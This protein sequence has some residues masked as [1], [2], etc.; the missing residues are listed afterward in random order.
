MDRSRLLEHTTIGAV[1]IIRQSS[2][3][4]LVLVWVRSEWERVPEPGPPDRHL[5]D[6]SDLSDPAQNAE[7]GELLRQDRGKI[8]DGLPGSYELYLVDIEKDDLSKLD[9]VPVFDWYLDTG[10]TFRVIDTPAH[11]RAGR[12]YLWTTGPKAAGHREKVDEIAPSLADYDATTT[13]ELLVLIAAD[14]AGPYV[15]IDGTHRSAALYR[16]HLT[17]TPWRAILALADDMAR[18]MWHID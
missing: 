5:I 15:I 9:I 14:V 12:G 18:S 1:Q 6:E 10:R 7:R 2:F 16:H 11:L 13:D 8:L 4:E 17:N 3:D